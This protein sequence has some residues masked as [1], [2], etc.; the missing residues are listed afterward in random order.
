MKSAENIKKLIKNTKIKTNPEVNKA[1]LND[2]LNRMD[3]A[4][5]NIN[6]RQQNIWRMIMK[7]KMTKFATAAVIIIAVIIGINQFGGSVD[8]A[9]VAWAEVVE[10]L[11]SHEKYKCRQRVVRTEGP[12]LPAMNVY[13]MNLSLRRQEVEDGSIHIIDMR[14]EDAITVELYPDQKRAIVTK[15]IGFGPKKDPD[16]IDMVKRFEQKST[17]R[18]GVKKQDGR[19]LQGFRHQ[20]NEYNDYTVWVDSETKLPIQIELVHTKA[21]QTV[22]LDEFEFDFDL[23]PSAF[24]TEVPEGYKVETLIQDYRSVEPKDIASEGIQ[25]KLNHAAYAVNELPWMEQICTIETIDPL[26]T[27]TIL[28]MTGIQT[29]D[30]NIIVMVQGDYYDIKKMVWIPNQKVTFES[31][32][33]VKL[34]EHPNGSIYAERFLESFAKAKPDFFDLANLSEEKFTRMIVMPDETVMGLVSNKQMREEMLREFI[35]SLTEIKA[36]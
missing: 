12:Q 18:L 28:Y 34:Y 11:N 15:G 6:A 2:L 9:S 23:K 3:H 8:M 26:G 14:A 19:I 36:N 1:V 30:G 17:E 13:H 25:S 22:F 5:G 24:S 4:G 27:K 35:E 16:I 29:N 20:P 33:G 21:G 32:N 31:S 10:Q 7:S